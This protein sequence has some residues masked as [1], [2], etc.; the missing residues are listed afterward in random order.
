MQYQNVAQEQITAT[1]SVPKQNK[2][3]LLDLE[4]T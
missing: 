2:V 3:K 4:V 1:N